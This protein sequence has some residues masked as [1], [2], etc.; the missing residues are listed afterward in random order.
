MEGSS[1]DAGNATAAMSDPSGDHDTAGATDEI[2]VRRV[3][4][5]ARS[6]V[7]GISCWAEA[8]VPRLSTVR[9]RSPAGAHCGSGI[10]NRRC[11][12]AL[13]APVRRTDA[14]PSGPIVQ[15]LP[16]SANTYRTAG[17]SARGV[18]AALAIGTGRGNHTSP[19]SMEPRS[20]TAFG[21]RPVGEMSTRTTV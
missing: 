16:P 5:P 21:A 10:V 13:L 14:T 7:T 15:T 9:T 18:T 19:E 17:A 11:V 4:L 20:S 12:C 2:A 8:P 6:I 1:G 3:T